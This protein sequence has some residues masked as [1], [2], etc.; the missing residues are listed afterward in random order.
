MHCECVHSNC[1][2]AA[3]R[4]DSA[5]RVWAVPIGYRTV[6]RASSPS[7][8]FVFAQGALRE[9][10]SWHGGVLDGRARAFERQ[11]GLGYP[12]GEKSA[13]DTA[14]RPLHFGSR[15]D[16]LGF[17]PPGSAASRLEFGR[18]SRAITN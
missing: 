8:L 9:L 7:G 13:F 15:M 14:G 12:V 1:C 17:C 2:V 11:C 6:P 10:A 4:E 3:A 18:R 16:T 5:A